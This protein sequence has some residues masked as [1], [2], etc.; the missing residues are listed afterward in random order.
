MPI[1]TDTNGSSRWLIERIFGPGNEAATTTT[2]AEPE[3]RVQ[4]VNITR[5]TLFSKLWRNYPVNSSAPEAYE[6]VGG[7]AWALHL[8]RPES[9]TN[10][11]ALRFS[12]SLNY[13]GYVINNQH[14]GFYTVKGEDNL[15]YLLR[16]KETIKY[17]KENFGAPTSTFNSSDISMSEVQSQLMGKTGIIIFE[18]TG[19]SDATGHVTLWN[20]STCGDSCYFN[21]HAPARTDKIIFWEIE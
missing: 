13:S 8:E 7:Q 17:V 3:V 19:W 1:P 2:P 11:C 5:D 14:S 15:N 10:A 20:G 21:P 16:V 12:R 9:Y 18:V 4:Q 6:L